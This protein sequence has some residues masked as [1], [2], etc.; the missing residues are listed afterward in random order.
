MTDHD[1]LI[2]YHFELMCTSDGTEIFCIHLVQ[3]MCAMA[4]HFLTDDDL[5]G[6]HQVTTSSI[7]LSK[8]LKDL[9]S[10]V[11]LLPSVGSFWFLRGLL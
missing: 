4:P 2:E 8:G 6:V 11:S 7:S 1:Q 3:I 5:N 9:P 10:L